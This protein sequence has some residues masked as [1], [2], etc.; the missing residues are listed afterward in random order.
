[1]G[2]TGDWGGEER[3]VFI[4]CWDVVSQSTNVFVMLLGR[5]QSE[6]Q[7]VHNVVGTWSIRVPMCL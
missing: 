5:G 6:Y 2:C 7:C 3:D 1:V 4:C